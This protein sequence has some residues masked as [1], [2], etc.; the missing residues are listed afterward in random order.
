VE[1]SDD[2]DSGLLTILVHG[3]LKTLGQPTRATLV[4]MGLVHGTSTLEIAGGLTG[5]NPIPM[6][7]PLEKA[8]AA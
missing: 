8:R 2:N 1:Q 7:A 3:R 6:D 5:V 4:A